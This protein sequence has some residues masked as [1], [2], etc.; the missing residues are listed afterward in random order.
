MNRQLTAAQEQMIEL[1]ATAILAEPWKRP[2][3]ERA[4]LATLPRELAVARG[5]TERVAAIDGIEAAI[6]AHQVS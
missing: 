2:L 5:D 4:W 6:A 3:E 1:R